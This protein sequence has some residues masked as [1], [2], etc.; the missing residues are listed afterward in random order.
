MFCHEH[1]LKDTKEYN[2]KIKISGFFWHL[3]LP[4]SCEYFQKYLVCIYKYTHNFNPWVGSQI[5]V[6]YNKYFLLTPGPEDS[7]SLSPPLLKSSAQLTALLIPGPVVSS[8]CLQHAVL[9]HGRGQKLR[10]ENRDKPHRYIS[11]F[12][13][14]GGILDVH[15]HFIG[16]SR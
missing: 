10:G 15:A 8:Y 1:V 5:S 6:A 16:Q 12:C 4:L 9:S 7:C 14:D 2:I 3:P 11:G 13:M